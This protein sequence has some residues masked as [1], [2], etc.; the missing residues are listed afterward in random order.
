[1]LCPEDTQFKGPFVS[2]PRR[3]ARYTTSYL[4]SIMGILDQGWPSVTFDASSR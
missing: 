1:M 4:N 3:A 2:V